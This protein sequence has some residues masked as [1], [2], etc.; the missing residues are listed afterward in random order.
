MV[1]FLINQSGSLL[2][3]FTLKYSGKNKKTKI[4]LLLAIK[5]QRKLVASNYFYKIKVEFSIKFF[6]DISLAVPIA[7]GVSFVSTSIVGTLI[8]EEKPKLRKFYVQ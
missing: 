7:N 6:L 2:F 3:Y 8:G 4:I 5:I 1:P